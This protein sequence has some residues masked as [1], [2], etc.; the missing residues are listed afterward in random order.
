[1]SIFYLQDDPFRGKSLNSTVKLK[2]NV[3]DA[4]D[5]NPVFLQNQYFGTVSGNA[6][7]VTKRTRNTILLPYKDA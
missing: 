2:I 1:M 6:L 3:L 7:P 4:D 5:L